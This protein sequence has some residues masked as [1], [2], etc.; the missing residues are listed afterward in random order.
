MTAKESCCSLLCQDYSYWTTSMPTCQSMEGGTVMERPICLGPAR[1]Q[2][3]HWLAA[4]QA[5]LDRVGRV[6]VAS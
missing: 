4:P 6:G 2:G 5:S 3:L 1:Q